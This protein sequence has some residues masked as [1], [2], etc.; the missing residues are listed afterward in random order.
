MIWY[1]KGSMWLISLNPSRG[2]STKWSTQREPECPS[3][4]MMPGTESPSEDRS[5]SAADTGNLR[6]WKILE[7]TA[8][9]VL[10]SR[11]MRSVFGDLINQHHSFSGRSLQTLCRNMQKPNVSRWHSQRGKLHLEILHNKNR[12]HQTKPGSEIRPSQGHL[13]SKHSNHTDHNIP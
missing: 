3:S 2:L 7:I 5:S 1:L 4:T 10:H 9:S 12:T 11:D 6:H 8:W 13:V